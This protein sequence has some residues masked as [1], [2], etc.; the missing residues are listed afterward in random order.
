MKKIIR[1][2]NVLVSLFAA[3]GW[4][5][6]Y[7]FPKSFKLPEL[8]CILFCIVL[9]SSMEVL[10]TK[11]IKKKWIKRSL[12]EKV[13]LIIAI[14]VIFLCFEYIVT[15][16]L[17]H[18]L[19]EDFN[20]YLV[21]GVIGF[22]LSWIKQ[23]IKE[24]MIGFRYKD[25]SVGHKM[26]KTELKRIEKLNGDNKE[27]FG[28]YNKSLAVKTEN[29]IF[30]SKR[31]LYVQEFLGIPYAKAP[32]G[33]LRWKAP[34]KPEAS[35]RV[36]E[37]Y[38]FG[39]SAIQEDVQTISLKTHKQSED[40]LTLNVWRSSKKDKS[41][42]LKPVLVYIHGG[43][44]MYGG[45]AEPLYSGRAFVKEFP[46]T[47][48]VSFNYRLGLFGFV[49]LSNVAG[50]EGFEDS[51]NLGILD[52]IMALNWVHDNIRSFGG[53]PD[54]VMLAGDT[55]GAYCIKILSTLEKSRGLFKKALLISCNKV[56]ME[57]NSNTIKVNFPELMKKF[58]AST[59]E[60]MQAITADKLKQFVAETS[61]KILY[62]PVID[63]K[64]IKKDVEQ[65]ISDGNSGD[66][67]FIYGIPANEFSTWI[68][69]ADEE[70]MYKW[71]NK[72]FDDLLAI[73]PGEK[74][75]ENLTDLVDYYEKQGMSEKEAKNKALAFIIYKY[76][77]LNN[78][79]DLAKQGKTVRCFY[80]N[81]NP[82]VKKYGGNSISAVG[83][84]LN[85]SNSA[86]SLGYITNP[87]IKKVFEHLI[88]NEMAS[89]KVEIEYDEVSGVDAFV[90]AP[91]S[92]ENRQV[93]HVSNKKVEMDENVLKEDLK[94]V[95][96]WKN[97]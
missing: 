55:M 1:I 50:G 70:T 46:G 95:E 28:K 60:E 7:S 8:L 17:N 23:A 9:G 51:C 47:I 54:N 93:L 96:N 10:G 56:H 32:V 21:S 86:E 22:F 85:T 27:I 81:V 63:G 59:M 52:Q 78:C 79:L 89:E 12:I 5:L 84:F 13:L 87:T 41:G 6:G 37:A 94:R 14:I 90:W 62:L 72:T 4:G 97:M 61:E 57:D 91:F 38:Y 48:V 35:D 36:W 53:D 24:Q 76:D 42:K 64:L 25:G 34:Q 31:D 92:S 16:F 69:V 83:A 30:V 19:M 66:I 49:N 2:E 68:T 11:V 77:S 82:P 65:A 3:I 58:G 74:Q 44:L 15:S 20:Y 67:R 88:Y 26:S 40:C 73:T 80:W 45:S 39:A 71:S 33:K 18:N 29:G 43:N 75:K